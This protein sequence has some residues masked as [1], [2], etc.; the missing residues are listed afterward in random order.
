[1]SS[2][3]HVYAIGDVTGRAQLTPVAIAAGRRL[4]DRVFGGMEDR[5]LDY[6]NIPTVVFGHPPIGTVGM[7]ESAARTEY[8]DAVTVFTS[9]FVSMY[10]AFTPPEATMRHENRHGR[11]LQAGGRCP[12]RR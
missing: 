9:S 4:V 3:E 2:V 10:H 1:M 12:H 6:T 5:H 11:P 8:G 7:T